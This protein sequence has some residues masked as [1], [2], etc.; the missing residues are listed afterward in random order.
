MGD[1]LRPANTNEA[2]ERIFLESKLLLADN[3]RRTY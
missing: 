3:R 1:E 2:V